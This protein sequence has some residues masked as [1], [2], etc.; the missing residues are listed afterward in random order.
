MVSS[1]RDAA[2]YL[3][4]LRATDKQ[5]LVCRET[6]P[7]LRMVMTPDQAGLW[8]ATSESSI[9]HWP[10]NNRLLNGSGGGNGHCASTTTEENKAELE[11]LV[12]VSVVFCYDSKVLIYLLLISW[13]DEKILVL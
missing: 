8:V 6:S 5:T 10:L 7:V 13:F 9:K 2:V 12:Q 4:D 1:G 11:P 3:T